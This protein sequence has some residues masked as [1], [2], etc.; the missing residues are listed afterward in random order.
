[1]SLTFSRSGEELDA[2]RG[3]AGRGA[4]DTT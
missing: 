3:W 1:L 4:E 2:G